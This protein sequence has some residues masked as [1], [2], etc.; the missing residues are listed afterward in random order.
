M[1]V[2]DERKEEYMRAGHRLALS[3]SAKPAE[4]SVEE[5]KEVVKE[6]LKA[7]TSKRT[8]RLRKK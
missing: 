2:A 4:V 7:V 1:W 5:A 6:E 8:S 3:P